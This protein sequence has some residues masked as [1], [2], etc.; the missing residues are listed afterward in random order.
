MKK[1]WKIVGITASISF[2]MFIALALFIKALGILLEGWF[3]K[4][5][6]IIMIVTGVIIIIGL[7]TGSI[8]IGAMVSKGKGLFG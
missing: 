2:V 6:L 8:S 1:K 4:N 5:S 7:I 3:D